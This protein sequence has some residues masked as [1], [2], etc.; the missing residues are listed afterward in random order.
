MAKEKE[1]EAQ[2]S[3]LDAKREKAEAKKAELSKQIDELKEKIL[4]E[5]DEKT[6]QKLRAQRDELMAQKDG[7]VITADKVKVPMAAAAKKKL[8]ACIAIICV[9]ALLF[10]YVATGAARH[11]FISSLGWPQKVLTGM[12]V[13]DNEG[14]KHGVKVSTYNY[15]FA[16]YYNN[17]KQS[18][19]YLSQLGGLISGSSDDQIDFDKSLAKQTTKDDDDNEITWAKKVEDTVL[20]NIKHTYGYYYAAVK[21][22]NGEEPEITE[23]QQNEIDE[24]L[25]T[26]KG[27]A[28]EYGFTL[29]AYLMAAMGDGV[30]AETVKHEMKVSYIAENYE[31]EFTEELSKKEYTEDEYNKYLEENRDDL[32]S[33]DVRFF[34][35]SNE[36]DAAAFVSELKADGS[37]FTELAVK[38]AAEDDKATYEEALESTYNNA[39]RSVFTSLNAAIAAAEEAESE[40]AEE[41]EDGEEAEHV[42]VYPGFDWLYSEDRKAGDKTNFS[43]SVVYVVKPVYLSDVTP[44]N[45]RHILIQAESTDDDGE[46]TDLSSLADAT[47]EQIAAAEAKAQE[48]LDEYNN[49][50]K[51]EDAFAELAK[52]YSKDSNASEGGL[53][54]NV[55]PNQ[56]VPTF[57]AWCFDASRKVGDVAIV[58]TEYGFHVMYFSGTNDM[59]V[60]KYTAQQALASDESA[61]AEKKFE[62]NIQ[63]KKCW[64]GSC[65]FQKDTDIDN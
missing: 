15:Y 37:N 4:S 8:T 21:A 55:V 59:P 52:E 30:D 42:H 49:G 14:D 62:E 2:L 53:Y 26:Y 28:D 41:T 9:I 46:T 44:V 22:N 51:T 54:E 6:K 11:G 48:V 45:V 61:D 7:I 5:N 1:M 58:K 3:K 50:E 25:E 64:P 19:S 60:W 29:S 38:Y 20:D 43:T 57:N 23:D 27:Y 40:D 10:A 65:Y 31:T 35:A 18:Q 16:V 13:T 24:L 12:T 34:E 39:T 17:L 47:D 32:V 36:D 56:M 63:I 33:V